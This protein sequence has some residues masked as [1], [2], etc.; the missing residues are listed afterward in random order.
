[1]TLAFSEHATDVRGERY[2]PEQVLPEESFAPFS[3]AMCENATSGGE[4]QP[5]VF[6]FSKLKDV[7]G[8]SNRKEI[9]YFQ[10]ERAGERRQLRLSAVGRRSQRLYESAHP[11][12][13][14]L[15]Q[16]LDETPVYLPHSPDGRDGPRR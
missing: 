14:S 6:D 4:L 3:I 7:K 10:R 15:W 11:V 5:P 16:R 1:M 8:F 2:K 12:D 9:V 13:R